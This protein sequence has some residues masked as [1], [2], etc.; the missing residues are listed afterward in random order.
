MLHILYYSHDQIEKN[1]LSGA[2]STHRGEEKCIQAFGG[3]LENSEL[4]E[5]PTRRCYNV[6]Q[7]SYLLRN[8]QC[9]ICV[10]LFMHKGTNYLTSICTPALREYLSCR[11]NQK[12]FKVSALATDNTSLVY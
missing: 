12:D 10:F 9:S 4:P 2:C 6:L 11:L 1:E 5:T 8:V 3:V 7:L